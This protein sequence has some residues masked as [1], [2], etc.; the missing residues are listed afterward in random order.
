MKDIIIVF[1]KKELKKYFIDDKR[2]EYLVLSEID[3]EF[4]EIDKLKILRNMFKKNK[5]YEFFKI[6][7][8]NYYQMIECWYLENLFNNHFKVYYDLL[9]YINKREEYNF[10]IYE[11]SRLSYYNEVIR[12]LNIKTIKKRCINIEKYSMTKI[13]CIEILKFLKLFLNSILRKKIKRI[14]YNVNQILFTD[15]VHQR[16]EFEYLTESTIMKDSFLGNISNYID[17]Y[18]YVEFDSRKK[19]IHNNKNKMDNLVVIEKFIS[20]RDFIEFFK[21]NRE[22]ISINEI[23]TNLNGI[24]ISNI[25]KHDLMFLLGYRLR[26]V[27]F[28]EKI[29]MKIKR[30]TKCENVIFYDEYDKIGRIINKVFKENCAVQHGELNVCYLRDIENTIEPKNTIVSGVYYK[31]KLIDIF[32]YNTKGI[33]VYGL[34]R[35]ENINYLYNKRKEFFI[36][37]INNNKIVIDYEYVTFFTQPLNQEINIKTLDFCVDFIMKR[38]KNK[39]FIIK[40]HPRDKFIDLYMKRYKEYENVLIIDHKVDSYYFLGISNFVMTIYSTIALEAAL[41]GKVP[42]LINLID[43][44]IVQY[45]KMGLAFEIR[46]NKE[47]EHVLDL[48]ENSHKY[49]NYESIFRINANKLAKVSGDICKKIAYVNKNGENY[50]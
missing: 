31:K 36:S 5:L 29:L 25:I 42:I 49:N 17:G 39:K 46:N 34:P 23:N 9:N 1:D 40:V 38:Y 13:K 50:E 45:K 37:R 30:I 3:T 47:L 6:N 21:K 35:Y 16:M 4:S 11:N 24:D 2:F 43:I 14:D 8:F 27:L 22:K 7:K 48:L 10:Y 32:N 41:M 15:T 18:L 33:N 28:L 19:L 20:L 44:D 12:A 26:E